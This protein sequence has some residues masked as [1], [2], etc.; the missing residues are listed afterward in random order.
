MHFISDQH[1]LSIE[2]DKLGECIQ[3]DQTKWTI[4][5]AVLL[6]RMQ[7]TDQ[8]GESDSTFQCDTMMLRSGRV[9]EQ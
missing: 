9:A 3:C 1:K 8:I 4:C 6:I 2:N 7:Q 5:N